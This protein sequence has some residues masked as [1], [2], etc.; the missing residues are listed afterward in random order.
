MSTFIWGKIKLRSLPDSFGSFQQGDILVFFDIRK[1]DLYLSNLEDREIYFNIACGYEDMVYPNKRQQTITYLNCDAEYF[2]IDFV[3][4][5]RSKKKMPYFD[6]LYDRIKRLQSVIK[7]LYQR[8]EVDRMVYFHT[9]TGNESS[10]NEYEEV[11]WSI[12]EFAD[13]FFERIVQ[14]KGF[15]PTIKAVFEK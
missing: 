10:I 12:D 2:S 4:D 1:N 6:D 8:P 13:K 3:M 14:D 11:N 9:E 5:Q 15:A 7:E